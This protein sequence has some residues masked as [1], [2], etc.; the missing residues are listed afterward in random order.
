MCADNMSPG[1]RKPTIW[2]LT[3]S[4]TS[5]AVQP[6]NMARSLKFCILK[7]DRLYY[8]CSENKGADQL[9]GNREADLRL[10]FRICKKPVFSQRRSNS[11]KPFGK[12]LFSRF[13]IPT[14]ATCNLSVLKLFSLFA[15]EDRII[16]LIVPVPFYCLPFIYVGMYT[17]D[18]SLAGAIFF[19]SS[20]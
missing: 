18:V 11:V 8:P 16:M 3:R 7:V 14:Y 20:S 15:Y 19:V 1:V 10:C 6:Q 4:D 5:R 13:T 17:A 9:L 2:I 12:E